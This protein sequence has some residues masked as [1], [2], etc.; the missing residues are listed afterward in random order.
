MPK[1][2]TKQKED[3][4]FKYI[5]RLA[6]SDLDGNKLVNQALTNIK[7]VGHRTARIIVEEAE[8]PTNVRIGTLSDEQITE[9]GNVLEELD[10][11]SPVW[12]LNRRKDYY[13]GDN[14]HILGIELTAQKGDDINRLRMIRCY[15]GTRHETGKKCR[16]QKTRSNGRKG[17]T[18]GVSKKRP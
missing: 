16:G 9:I 14:K 4:D 18:M 3:D 17:T 5:V 12:L 8:V 2:E 13:S 10:E 11:I 1:K 15:R 7:G 6:N